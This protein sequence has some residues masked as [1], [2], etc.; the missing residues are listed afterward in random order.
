MKI[1]HIALNVKEP[2]K[3]AWWYVSQLNMQVVKAVK[4]APYIHFL[5][6]ETGQS[7][8]EIYNNPI[9]PIP[10]YPAMKSLEL[11]IAFAVNDIEATRTRLI[12]AGATAEGDINQLP[13]GDQL[14][15]LRDPWGVPLQLAKRA[16]P[17]V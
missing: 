4:E 5:A 6:D 9:A 2:V 11:H 12:A 8:I 14:T 10:D 7:M 3:M 16:K 1:E 13:N 15:M 17:M